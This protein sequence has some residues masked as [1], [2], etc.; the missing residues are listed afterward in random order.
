ML[1]RASAGLINNLL[2][3]D[4]IE[5]GYDIVAY[6]SAHQETAQRSFVADSETGW[7]VFGTC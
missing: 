5:L 6:F 1:E 7:V 3:L 4:R 2:S